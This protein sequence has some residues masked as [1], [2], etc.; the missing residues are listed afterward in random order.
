MRTISF[1][2]YKGGVG[3]SLLVANVA[4]YLSILGKKVVAIDLDLEAP[5]L[6][7]KFELG[8]GVNRS[9]SRA[10][11]VDIL[12]YFMEH[13]RFPGSIVDYCADVKVLDG[14]GRI[15][16]FRAGTA[17]DSSYWRLLSKINWHDFFYGSNPV[18]AP[19]FLELQEQIAVELDPDF[20]LVDA[21]T[22]ITE[23]SGVATTLLPEIVVCLA[24]D[25][26]EHLHGLRAVMHGINHTTAREGRKVEL[27]PVISRVSPKRDSE[28]SLAPILTFLNEPN[29]S[30]AILGLDEIITLHAEPFL[31]N[32][33]LLLVGGKHGPQESLLLRDYMRLFSKLVPVEE[34]RPH[35]GQLIQRAINRL[36]DDPDAAQGELEALTTYCADPEAYRALIKL[37]KV[38]KTPI[39]KILAAINMMWHLKKSTEPVDPIISEIIKLAF[40]DTRYVDS[41][42]KY[43]MFA[44]AVWRVSADKD[45]ALCVSIAQALA[46]DHKERAIRLLSDYLNQADTLN[47]VAVVKLLEIIRNDRDPGRAY[48]FIEKYRG[49]VQI[50][51]FYSLWAEI[52]AQHK[53]A[54]AAAL[55][56]AEPGFRSGLVKGIEPLSAYR[57]YRLVGDDSAEPALAEAIDAAIS[58]PR[59]LRLI[60]ELLN[61]EGRLDEFETRLESRLPDSIIQELIESVRRSARRG[62]AQYR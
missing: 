52:V 61:E 4:Q 31:D 26:A 51:A 9:P 7:Y 33:E 2:S 16:V 38:R 47:E 45:D 49:R 37:Y 59:R 12:C 34:V 17:P 25:S 15:S 41:Q 10:G 1:Y 5:G 53:D 8:A 46:P 18:G 40:L 48:E 44:E 57:L 6:H 14:A 29:E 13:R 36:L 11:V 35:V 54:S 27:L 30:G 62:W 50:P 42:K 32:G 24:L 19:F 55:L 58:H 60:A 56:L 43:A 28:A 22:G 23:M 3:R 20:L 21:R 39:D